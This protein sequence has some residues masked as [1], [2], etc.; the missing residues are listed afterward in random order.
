M[1]GRKAKDLCKETETSQTIIN[2][3]SSFQETGTR[4]WQDQME[5]SGRVL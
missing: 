2:N 1:K 3:Q 5:K 4:N